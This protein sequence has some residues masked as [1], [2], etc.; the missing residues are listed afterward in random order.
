M[1][2][3]HFFESIFSQFSQDSLWVYLLFF[4]A[5]GQDEGAVVRT[6]LRKL[7]LEPNF[8]PAVTL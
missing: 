3:M 5:K 6:T 7:T 8:D 4:I 1:L 2:S